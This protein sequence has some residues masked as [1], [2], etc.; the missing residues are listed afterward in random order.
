MWKKKL[1]EYKGKFEKYSLR[2]KLLR[3]KKINSNFE[4]VLNTLTME[5]II[6]LK[7]ELSAAHVNHNPYNS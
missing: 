2:N 1:T 5:E 3:Q 7:L 4:T 6:A